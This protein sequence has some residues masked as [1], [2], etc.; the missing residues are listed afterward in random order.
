MATNKISVFKKLLDILRYEKEEISAIYFYTIFSGLVQLSLPL[1]IQAIISFVLGGAISTSLVLLII[2]VIT[3]VFVGGLLQVNQMKL[4]EKIQ[5][6]LFV[7]YSFQYAH[8]IPN[9]NLKEVDGYYLPELVNRFFDTISLQ[10]GISKLLL[11][12]P[13]A[14]IQI[15]FGL[16]LLSFYHPIFIFF[17]IMLLVVL[18]FI[19]RAT[20]GRGLETSIIESNYKYN[21]AGYLQELA[22]VIT[23]L[24]FSRNNSMHLYKTDEYVAGYL[25]SRTAHFKILLFQYWTLIGF[26]VVITSA[27]LIIGGFLLVNQQLN[28]GQFIAAEIV[29]LMVIGSVEK[30]IINL[31]KV[32]DVL[33]SVEKITKVLEKP[34]EQT[35]D[36]VLNE[37]QPISIRAQNLSFEYS[38]GKHTLSELTFN[39]KA[40]EIVCLQGA[41]TAGKSTLLRLL[42]GAFP[43][44]EG[45]LLIND[46][47]IGNYQ[48][49]SLRANTGIMLQTQDIFQGTLK[50]NICMG[51]DGIS[52]HEMDKLANIVGLKPFIDQQ[53]EGYNLD[54]QPAGQHLSGRIVKKVLLMRA[55]IHKPKLLLL[56][57]P[58]LG[59][60]E[61]YA[62]QI[63]H[64]LLHELPGTTMLI[65]SNDEKFSKKC[66]KVIV[67]DN[68][69]AKSIIE[70]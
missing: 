2:M 63:Q 6:Q 53:R 30:L 9:L 56:E 50:E 17:G 21:V 62:E 24:K 48:V 40:G 54:L 3:G 10:K 7:R 22:R 49:A 57:E 45:N 31:D 51:E 27:M 13:A 60:E 58:W 55:L 39:I 11:D 68:G 28:I 1:G 52:Y 14:T 35:G 26:K 18:Y 32:Y 59:L 43:L 47:P 42:T 44:F 41:Y 67:L 5:Q 20:S 23:S 34:M 25:Q 61:P 46:I 38:Q 29:I 8:I 37:N 19:L 33:T 66:D 64:Y 65:V 15:I 16:I 70:N 69:R 36:V 4:I 12:V